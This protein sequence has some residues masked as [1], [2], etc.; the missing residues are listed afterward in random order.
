MAL[1]KIITKA[2]NHDELKSHI[3]HSAKMVGAA[4]LNV[5]E[6]ET[7]PSSV[8]TA[9]IEGLD[10]VGIDYIF[11]IIAI[12][13]N[14][15]QE[16]AEKFIKGLNEIYADKLFSVYF[17]NIE[18][19]GMANT[20]RPLLKNAPITVGEVVRIARENLRDKGIVATAPAKASAGQENTTE[21]EK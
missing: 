15:Q 14:N 11:E 21:G 1:I 16:I 7:T 9:Y 4:V 6:C 12:K 20:P 10:L 8:E 13:R 2:E 18:E 3:A 19:D 5:P 17:N